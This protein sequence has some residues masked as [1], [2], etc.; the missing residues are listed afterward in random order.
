[1]GFGG[2]VEGKQVTMALGDA[3]NEEISSTLWDLGSI[4]EDS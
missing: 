2:Q 4:T 3:H 1:M